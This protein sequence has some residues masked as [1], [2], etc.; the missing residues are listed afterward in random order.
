MTRNKSSTSDLFLIEIDE[1]IAEDIKRA[2]SFINN[3]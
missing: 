1:K 3:L 2:E